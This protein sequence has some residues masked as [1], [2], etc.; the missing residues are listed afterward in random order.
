MATF[1]GKGG[2]VTFGAGTQ[3]QV[4]SWTLTVTSD[5][6]EATDM[7]DTWKNYLSG[8]KDWT[9]TVEVYQT[10]TGPDAGTTDIITA[11][12]VK[13]TL[14]LGDGNNDHTSTTGAILTDATVVSS[15]SDIV[16]L[17]LSF[18]GCA[19]IT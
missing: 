13:T 17:S 4:D 7:D 15:A 18:Q 14:V 16:R 8:M 1:H 10:T 12:G 6:V 11:L 3:L 2:E 19:A 5:V 9:A